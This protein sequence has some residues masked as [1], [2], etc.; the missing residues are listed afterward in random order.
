MDYNC[1][2]TVDIESVPDSWIGSDNT[3]NRTFTIGI[4]REEVVVKPS[5]N[6]KPITTT[7]R[8]PPSLSP[9]CAL[10]VQRHD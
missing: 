5:G 7:V 1:K 4:G 8:G 3:L 2:V 9:S 10:S 6:F